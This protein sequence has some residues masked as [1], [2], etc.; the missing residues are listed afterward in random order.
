MSNVTSSNGNASAS[1]S[2]KS[3]STFAMRAFSRARSSNSGVRST[4]RTCAPI[5]AAVIATTPVPQPT[6][7]A[8]CPPRTFANFTKRAAAGVV[9]ASSGAKCFQPCRC[10]SLNLAMASSLMH[11]SLFDRICAVSLTRYKINRGWRRRKL[12]LDNEQLITIN[13]RNQRVVAC[14]AWLGR[15]GCI[16]EKPGQKW[17]YNEKG[18]QRQYARRDRNTSWQIA[19]VDQSE[20]SHGNATKQ[21]DD[22]TE[23]RE[24][25][26]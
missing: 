19:A 8:L 1:P 18:H 10:A 24:L 3:I 9:S 15:L 2:R 11:Q 5:R 17:R 12:T 6:S 21:N 22:G 23:K 14:S 20:I 25:Q 13:S 16:T 7:R 26:L 4:P